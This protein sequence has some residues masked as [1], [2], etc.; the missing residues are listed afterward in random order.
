MAGVEP[1]TKA[2][3]PAT[4]GQSIAA[5]TVPGLLKGNGP[6]DVVDLTLL[7]GHVTLI[8]CSFSCNNSEVN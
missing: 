7:G 2:L 6:A 1:G 3:S 8:T 4:G 5:R